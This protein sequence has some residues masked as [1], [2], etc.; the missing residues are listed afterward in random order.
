MRAVGLPEEYAQALETG[1]WDNCEILP[2]GETAERGI[3][4]AP[5]P[6]LWSA[7]DKHRSA[8]A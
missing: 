7:A 6:V 5:P 1:L 3:P 4:L 8:A 2:A